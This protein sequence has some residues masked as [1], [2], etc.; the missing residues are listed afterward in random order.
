MRDGCH[1]T[2]ITSHHP[3]PHWSAAGRQRSADRTQRRGPMLQ[4]T[5]ATAC[6]GR[7]PT[8]P[9]PEVPQAAPSTAANARAGGLQGIVLE[10]DISFSLS[11]SDPHTAAAGDPQPWASLAAAE[12]ARCVI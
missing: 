4:S 6:D 8:L 9:R 7:H 12:P 3:H 1:F 11:L 5:H 10:L 2:L